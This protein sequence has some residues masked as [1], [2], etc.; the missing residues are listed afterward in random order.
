MVSGEEIKVSIIIPI[1]N[2]EPYV[3]ECLQSVAHQTYCGEIECILVDDCGADGSM[4]V[5][6]RFIS[7]YKGDIGFRIVHHKI[8]RGLSAARNTGVEVSTGEYVYFLDSDDWIDKECI[9]Q[10][11]NK[12]KKYPH[13]DMVYAGAVSISQGYDILP[14][15]LPEFISDRGYIMKT[16]LSGK[17]VL[18]AWNKFIRK[19]FLLENKISFVEGM[20]MEDTFYS[21]QLL[22]NLRTVAVCKMNLYHYTYPREGSIMN[23]TSFEDYTHSI[24]PYISCFFEKL[25]NNE[26]HLQLR[27][28][29]ELLQ[30]TMAFPIYEEDSSLVYKNYRRLIE[31]SKFEDKFYLFLYAIIP[32]RLR[33][34]KLIYRYFRNRL[35]K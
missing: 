4:N 35:Y 14:V 9:E 7:D 32:R 27:Y 5:A 13:V 22:Q 30:N 16:F 3:E 18:N 12:V 10:L 1:Y 26:K 8:N 31:E 28:I 34:I 15:K 20:L 21:F 33:R 6:K 25:V 23:N 24:S 2:V 29:F 17:I 11:T 19:S